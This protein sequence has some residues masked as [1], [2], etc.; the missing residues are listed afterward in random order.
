[1]RFSLL[2]VSTLF[3]SVSP[4]FAYIEAPHSLGKCV[5]TATNIVYMEV[6]R[7]NNEKNLIIYKKIADLKGKH[8]GDEIKHNIGKKGFHEREWKN[9]MAWAEVGKKAI[10][11][12]NNEGSETCI[13]KYWYQA[14]K[15]GEWWG[16]SH[17]EPF[18]LRT[19]Y[20]DPAKLAELIPRM[21]KGEEVIVPCLAD[22]NKEQMHL[23]KGKVQRMRASLKKEEYDPKR[24][25]VGWGAGEDSDEPEFKTVTVLAAGAKDW[26]FLPVPPKGLNKWMAP[27]FDDSKWT[28]GKAPIGYGEDEIKQRGGTEIKE[29]G[30]DFYFRREF[31]LPAELLKTGNIIN[32]MVA[33]DDSATVWINGE[34]ADKD[35]EADHEFA[36]WNRDVELPLKLFK[37]GKNIVAVQVKNQPSSSDLYL[38]MEI[39][40]QIPLPKPPKKKDTVAVAPKDPK[41]P[42]TST[43]PVVPKDDP[44]D[45]NAMMV[46]T[47]N[48]TIILNGV[49]APRKLPHLD[50]IYPIEVIGTY[51]S[52]RGQKAHETVVNFKGIKPSELA[53]ALTDL[54]LKPGKPAYGEGK[55]AQGPEVKVY[56][57]IKQA[58]GKDKRFPIEECLI[59]NKTG[60]KMPPLK[61][62]FTGSALKQPDPEKEETVYGA[63][64][65]G[66]FL[67]L[68]PVTADTVL[69]T[70]MTMKDEPNWKLEIDPKI[71]P[72]EG[73]AI[74]LV[75]VVP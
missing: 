72:K 71:I 41:N 49:V 61:W 4:S 28:R 8:N 68:F 55:E 64:L 60:K 33:S 53:K 19:F 24:D 32:L 69:Q 7:V 34:L 18:L 37:P 52:P 29:K 10:F 36:Y 5:K 3:V 42:S 31:E 2:L 38:D 20:G 25:F 39:L 65:T 23:R 40:V 45:P 56:L 58:D 43:T 46:D 57:E 13:D 63:D 1:M 26:R 74:K 66:T 47:K 14:Y 35:P 51:A 21:L 16:M 48:K 27:D 17:A 73:T 67:A 59:H 75:I 15:E 12:Y 62:V 54:G 6:V 30:V 9:I 11:M 50:Q 22:G 44:R 70:T